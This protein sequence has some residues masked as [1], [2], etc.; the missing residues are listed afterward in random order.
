[1]RIR[2]L[3]LTGLL[4][5]FSATSAQAFTAATSDP[6]AEKVTTS[7]RDCRNGKSLTVPLITWG[8]DMVT[9]QA[10]GGLE[11][12]S[13]SSFANAGLD[14]TLK[15]V[16][17]FATQLS[18]YMSCKTPFLRATV[19]MGNLASELTGADPRTE[20][21]AV[22]QHSWSNGG[23]AL[24][25][26]PGIDKPED[27]KG[28]RIAVQAYGPHVDYLLTVLDDAGLGVD[29]VEIVWTDDLTGLT[30]SSPDTALLEG[31]A[32]AAMVIIPDA[33][34]LTSDG[35]VG[36]GSEGSVKGAT[37]L[38]STKTANRVIADVYYVRADFLKNNPDTVNAFVQA[39]IDSE[40]QVTEITRKDG[41]EAQKLYAMGAK[42]LLDDES[43]IADAKGLWLD[44]ETV[45]EAGNARFF[46][47]P[48]YQRRYDRLNETIQGKYIALR[49]LTRVTEVAG[50]PAAI[51]AFGQ[52]SG[53]IAEARFNEEAVNKAVADL[54]A[55]GVLDDGTL[56]KFE[57]NFKPNQNQFDIAIYE[58]AF[59]KAVDLAATY[60]GALI[61][62]EGHAD[63][64]NFLKKK[65]KGAGT[66][67]LKQIAQSARNLSFNRASA[68]RESLIK[69]AESENLY[70]DPSQFAILGL[71][72]SDPLTGMCGDVP[73][74]PKSKAEWL[75]NM[76][77][78]FRIIQ[79]EA[80]A[81]DFELLD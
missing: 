65:K 50:P 63:P 7:V 57:L 43:A 81:S 53:G 40:K 29:D 2:V 61:T 30:S 39:L 56:F 54:Q 26:T 1:M 69:L 23:D 52:S 67:E 38:L 80:E 9:I 32:D 15:R 68:V 31:K 41:S 34:A 58:D 78:V 76:R 64:L 77:V 4:A 46:R 22:Y 21:V 42:I 27:L 49:M 24:V 60:G 10:N 36:N 18:D 44:A 6:L 70:M 37:I 28:K 25:V 14:I 74:A 73:C 16:D 55:Q 51:T 17:D 48:N 75:S 11:T 35:N 33:L 66:A 8:A 47:D 12:V 79:V 59:M 13:G 71:G 5:A 45:G 72:F 19:G 20:M 62:V 3:A